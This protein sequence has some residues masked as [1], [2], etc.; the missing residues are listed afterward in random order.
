M[1]R[2]RSHY[3]LVLPA[4]ALLA[5]GGGPERDTGQLPPELQKDLELARASSTELVGATAT[6]TQVVSGLEAGRAGSTK[7]GDRAEQPTPAPRARPQQAPVLRH[8]AQQV[9]E[10][11][12]VADPASESPAPAGTV[13][14]APAPAPAAPSPEPEPV[15]APD[16]VILAGP[17]STSDGVGSS[18]PRDPGGWGSAG[19]GGVGSGGGLGGPAGVIIRGGTIG[20]DDHCEIRPRGGRVVGRGIPGGTIYIPRPGGNGPISGGTVTRS[21]GGGGGGGGA[22]ATPSRGRS[23]GG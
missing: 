21:R 15:A 9:V 6:G 19:T 16:P 14:E 18:R 13:A 8:A 20:D 10:A 22:A 12:P 17:Q 7:E 5:C 23:R 2:I 4:A 3:L 11:A 1:P